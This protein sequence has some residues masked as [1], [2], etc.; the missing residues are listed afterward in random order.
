MNERYLNE[1]LESIDSGRIESALSYKRPKIRVSVIAMAA[2]LAMAVGIGAFVFARSGSQTVKTDSSGDYLDGAEKSEPDTEGGITA[3]GSETEKLLSDAPITYTGTEITP[4]QIRKLAEREKN[5]IAQYVRSENKGLEGEICIAS[6][7]YSYLQTSDNTVALDFVTLPVFTG[8]R[9]IGE[10]VVYSVDGKLSYSVS[11][12]GEGWEKRTEAF[13]NSPDGRVCFVYIGSLREAMIA[14][15][16]RVFD[17]RGGAADAF[18][19]IT[20]LFERYSDPHNT[21]SFK[22]MK[23]SGHYVTADR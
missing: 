9:I 6:E 10:A 1:A 8:D 2:A 13:A 19:G 4:E 12:G 17:L 15:D 22:E 11:A 14:P 3:G 16:S 5:I 18:E 23:A 20:G 7:G 21:Y